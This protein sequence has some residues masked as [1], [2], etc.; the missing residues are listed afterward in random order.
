M[1]IGAKIQ[2][3]F[4][5]TPD[6]LDLHIEVCPRTTNKYGSV[7]QFRHN[8]PTTIPITGNLAPLRFSRMTKL[9][10]A[11]YSP[12]QPCYTE[13]YRQTYISRTS[14]GLLRT[15]ITTIDPIF[16]LLD[17]YP[18][19]A[20]LINCQ[21]NSSFKDVYGYRLSKYPKQLNQE[22]IKI[23]EMTKN[24]QFWSLLVLDEEGTI[25]TKIQVQCM[26]KN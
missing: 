15:K 17:S 9:Y 10:L 1:K 3:S 26:A 14:K 19:D 18:R 20:R 6:E 11:L 23:K 13:K 24:E 22:T 21:I 25:F 7:V 12:N 2:I 8:S 4:Q 16:E 5:L